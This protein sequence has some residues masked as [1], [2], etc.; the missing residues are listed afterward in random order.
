MLLP[1]KTQFLIIL[2]SFLAGALAGIIFDGYRLIRGF[3]VPKFVIIIEDILF[4][5]LCSMTVF[6][7]LLEFNQAFLNLYVYLFIILGLIFYLT[8]FSKYIVKIEN[9][10]SI[11][12]FKIIRIVFKNMRY[13]FKNIFI[14]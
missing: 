9:Y 6:V 14:K 8:F 5:I 1:L 3:K 12:I 10:L 11:A 7:F 4:W 13:L 2:F